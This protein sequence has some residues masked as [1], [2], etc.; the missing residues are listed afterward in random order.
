MFLHIKTL[1]LKL[2]FTLQ[3]QQS[4]RFSRKKKKKKRRNLHY[5]TR[6][7]LTPT[8]RFCPVITFYF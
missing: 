6:I 5:T 2:L 3:L 1:H 4:A 8:M 7:V